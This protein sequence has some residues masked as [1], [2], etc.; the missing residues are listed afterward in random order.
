MNSSKNSSGTLTDPLFE[1]PLSGVTEAD[2]IASGRDPAGGRG[3]QRFPSG[4]SGRMWAAAG[5]ACYWFIPAL[6]ALYAKYV[7]LVPARGLEIVQRA[8][9]Q[10]L[11]SAGSGIGQ[12][13][14]LSFYRMDLLVGFLLVPAAYFLVAVFLPRWWSSRI[15]WTS[16]TALA[17]MIYIQV[18]AL[19]TSGTYISLHTLR[20]AVSWGLREPLANASFLG[21]GSAALLGVLAASS[22]LIAGVLRRWVRGSR[23]TALPQEAKRGGKKFV[24]AAAL[25]LP[26][27]TVF[28]WTRP[29][30][31]TVFHRSAMIVALRAYA[32]AGS[33]EG[34]Q[35]R[36]FAREMTGLTIPQLEARYR[37]LANAP[38]AARDA[39]FWAKAQG[40]NVV[41]FI[42][43]TTPTRFLSVT[44]DLSAFPHLQQ[45]R[46]HSFVPTRHYTTFP[47]T[48][49]A[50]YSLFGS[51]YPSSED[52][53]LPEKN[54]QVALPGMFRALASSG[55]QT[56][57]YMPFRWSG[58]YD[59]QM[60]EML[61]VNRRV[62]P[63]ASTYSSVIGSSNAGENWREARFEHDRA[64][65]ALLENDLTGWLSNQTKFA[66]VFLPQIGH[67]PLPLPGDEVS[68]SESEVLSREKI[69]LETEDQWLGALMQLLQSH[70]ALEHTLIV[71]TGDH[72]IRVANEDPAF[73]PGMIDDNSFEV[74][75]LLYAPGVLDR[76][77]WIPWVTSHIDVAPT[78]LDLLG[79]SGQRELM[80]GIPL[81]N[82]ALAQRTTYFFAARLFGADGYYKNK[83]FFMSSKRSGFAYASP[84]LHFDILDPLPEYSGRSQNVVDSIGQMST[85]QQA[86]EDKLAG[87]YPPR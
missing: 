25:L 5:D 1:K 85:L 16:S 62:Y 17:L 47:V 63:D 70:H 52:L 86:L 46:E 67:V 26:A 73:T 71:V 42:L 56:A 22:P 65:L 76:T 19:E 12:W 44:G 4:V 24:I 53:S 68:R 87:A 80:E 50:L 14:A 55:Y 38:A 23:G 58:E 78:V 54:V 59:D 39:A 43:E 34:G 18:R 20:V 41:F 74:P 15:A 31:V 28:A 11:S 40:Y 9:S 6:A 51:L 29:S 13:Q 60:F 36:D 82:A 61:G 84:Q 33:E 7:T 49:R 45:L 66:A 3:Q 37:E 79:I 35:T 83:E 48:H 81:W 2:E 10:N 69:I 30:P 77:Q 64:A 8:T 21:W 57:A 75:F 27:V 72:G 32:N